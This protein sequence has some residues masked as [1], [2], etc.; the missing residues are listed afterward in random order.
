MTEFGGAVLVTVADAKGSSPRDAGVRMIVRPDGGAS[1]HYRRW[2]ARVDRAGGS[3][4][5]AERLRQTQLSSVSRKSLGPDLGQ[6]CGGWVAVTLERFGAE[7]ISHIQTLAE[8][9]RQ[10]SVDNSVRRDEGPSGARDRCRGFF[11]GREPPRP[12][13]ACPMAALSNAS[14]PRQHRSICLALAMS[15]AALR[16]APAPLPFAVTWIDPRPNA[17]PPHIPAN[18]I[19]I[20]NV[21]PA[22]AIAEA[23]T[24]AFVAINDA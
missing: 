22:R 8:A 24:G 2:H 16:C 1:G 12:T 21:D 19:C 6:C 23:P 5:V 13:S 11:G 10:W 7:D 15:G 20:G 9:E 14:S 4:G 18:V 3:A 17:F